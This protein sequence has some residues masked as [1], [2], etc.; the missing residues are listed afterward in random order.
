[1]RPKQISS[2]RRRE[3]TR[4]PSGLKGATASR[5]RPPYGRPLT[6]ETTT[7]LQTPTPHGQTPT[8][9]TPATP[10]TTAR[11]AAQQRVLEGLASVFR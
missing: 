5:Q 9:P 1:M 11:T 2:G 4:P 10:P 7:A 8:A 3:G 6:P